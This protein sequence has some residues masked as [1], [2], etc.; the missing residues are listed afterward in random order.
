MAP[1]RRREVDALGVGDREQAD[2]GDFVGYLEQH[3]HCVG[4]VDTDF[5]GRSFVVTTNPELADYQPLVD[6]AAAALQQGTSSGT[7]EPQDVAEVIF[8]AAT[9]GTS[10]LR[11]I[12]GDGA[13]ALLANQ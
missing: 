4:D 8:A 3:R 6:M 7:Q 13:Q 2:L 11:Y 12:S 5:G 1:G 10:R 9:D